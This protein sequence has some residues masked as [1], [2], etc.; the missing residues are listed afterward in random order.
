MD[1]ISRHARLATLIRD[2]LAADLA[3]LAPLPAAN[4][5]SR[6][7]LARLQALVDAAPAFLLLLAEPWLDDEP[8]DL[9]PTLLDCA[10]I[11]LYARILDDA[12]DESLP[13]HHIHLLRYQPIFW[14]TVA[15]LAVRYPHLQVQCAHL[16]EET[17]LAVEADDASQGPQ[18]WGRKNH[19]LLLL[20]LLLSAGDG[21]YHHHRETLS[22]LISLSQACDEWW[23]GELCP[24]VTD[25]VLAMFPQW[26]DPQ[27]LLS[28]HQAGWCLA[29]AHILR[30]GQYLLDNLAH[31]H[32]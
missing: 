23:Q 2:K 18:H 6:Q 13:P 26:M 17:V 16:I 3:R 31:R 32:T 29:Q 1:A 11:H 10:R 7:A 9:L 22:A 21:R 5:I 19:H 4:A 25:A 27:R 20:P 12:L 14:Q 30:E 28:L 24:V 8:E 15:S